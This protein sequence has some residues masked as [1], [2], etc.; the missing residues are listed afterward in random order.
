VRELAPGSDFGDWR[1]DRLIGRGGMGV[2]YL[3]TDRRLNRPVAIKLIAED[4]ASDPAFRERFE[5]EAQLTAAIDHPNVIPVYSAGEID[6]QLYLATRFVDGT[7]L[8]ECLRREGPLHPQRAAE[9][10]QQVAEALDAA[11]AAGL[12]HRDVKPANVLL[13]GRHAYLSDFGLTRSVESTAQL[14]DTDERLGTVDFMSPE[15]L[16]GQRVDARS[17]VYALGCLLFTALTGRPPFHRGTAAATITAHLESPP[18]RAS[19]HAGVPDEF[20]VVIGRALEKDPERRYPSAGD[21][22]RAAVAAAEGQTTRELGQSV[23]RGEAAPLEETRPVELAPTARVA[24]KENKR[25]NLVV[26]AVVIAAFLLIALVVIAIALAGGGS[27]PNRALSSTDVESAARNFA[28]AYSREDAR[29]LT[30][31]LAPDVRRVSASDVQRGRSSVI[32]AYRSQFRSQ[33]TRAYRLADLQVDAGPVGR[34]QARFTVERAGRPP[35]TGQVVLG[36]ERRSG[37]VRIRL[38][39]TESRI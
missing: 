27:N 3:A 16:R 11:H 28:R 6:D 7:D 32:A 18:P 31:L 26:E 36:V 33:V 1:I 5:R 38:I 39:A 35:I 14:T 19:D 13:S 25:R 17:D 8:Q 29:A 24:L 30:R 22:G 15:Q 21:L 20:D 12:V 4:R 23:A 2:V 37:R 34:A 9:V 10:V